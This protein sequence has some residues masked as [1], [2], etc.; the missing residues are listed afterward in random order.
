MRIRRFQPT[1]TDAA[2]LR[3]LRLRS[4]Q[5]EPIAFSVGY[6][7]I[8]E[9]PIEAI[10]E[11]LQETDVFGA[12]MEDKLIGMVGMQRAAGAKVRHRATIGGMYVIPER[13]R[14]GVGRALLEAVLTYTRSLAGVRYVTL[15][16]VIA[17]TTAIALY[18]RVG[19]QQWGVEP[20]AICVDGVDYDLAHL[21]LN[22]A[23]G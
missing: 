3:H 14:Q 13:R 1:T 12:W 21:V 5:E 9:T 11:H 7:E 20:G 16:V 4:V 18:E 10:I 15:A 23:Q 6:D 17:P 8:N 2:A 22:L 19:F